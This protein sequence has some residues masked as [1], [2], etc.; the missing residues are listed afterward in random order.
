MLITNKE[1]H[2]YMAMHTKEAQWHKKTYPTDTARKWIKVNIKKI[3]KYKLVLF[4]T[5]KTAFTVVKDKDI[6]IRG[7][8]KHCPSL[9]HVY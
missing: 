9:K 5:G 4:S 8:G 3:A 1:H 2:Y 6:L 7:R